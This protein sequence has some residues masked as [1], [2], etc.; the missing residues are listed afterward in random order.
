MIEEAR[1][2]PHPYVSVVSKIDEIGEQHDALRYSEIREPRDSRRAPTRRIEG[3]DPTEQSERQAK[4]QREAQV[5]L[6]PEVKGF[7]QIRP[8]RVRERLMKRSPKD[9]SQC[10]ENDEVDRGQRENEAGESWESVEHFRG[11]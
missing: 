2:Q 10:R 9:N 4:E 6:E 5:E 11:D 8:R 1:V 3:R 7:E